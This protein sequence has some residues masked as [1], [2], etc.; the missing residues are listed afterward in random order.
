LRASIVNPFAAFGEERRRT[1]TNPRWNRD[2]TNNVNDNSAAESFFALRATS[3][4]GKDQPLSEYSDKVVLVVNTASACGFTPQYAGLEQLWQDYRER[5]LVVLGFPS[6]DFGGQ[7][8][9]SAEEIRDFCD[10]RFRITFPMFEK[11]ETKGE[12]QSPV[13]KFLT[14]SHPRPRWNF[15]KYLVGRDGQVIDYFVS[16]TKPESKR[17]RKRIE[18]AL[19]APVATSASA[20]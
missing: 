20:R 17:M 11:I 13:F 9:G 4:D 16:L 5:G 2:I 15:Y 18:A 12:R 14:A 10:A 19:D 3:L 7:E 6:N 1:G 8:P